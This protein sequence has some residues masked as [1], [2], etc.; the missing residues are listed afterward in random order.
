MN[1]LPQECSHDRG[2]SSTFGDSGNGICTTTTAD[3]GA[4]TFLLDAATNRLNSP[5]TYL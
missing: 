3:W 2:G 5:A 4:Q 1:A